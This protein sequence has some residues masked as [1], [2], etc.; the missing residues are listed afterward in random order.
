MNES[1]LIERKNMMRDG[2]DKDAD[3]DSD[4]T[5][6]ETSQINDNKT[7]RRPKR[8]VEYAA[9]TSYLILNLQL[10]SASACQLS[11]L[12]RPCDKILRCKGFES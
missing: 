9:A 3:T 4:A 10:P 7:G 5:K 12:D 6:I 8:K 11:S 2:K 1:R